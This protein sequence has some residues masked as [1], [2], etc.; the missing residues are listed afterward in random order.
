[1]R[2]QGVPFYNAKKPVDVNKN[3]Q[4]GVSFKG[5][6]KNIFNRNT[7]MTLLMPLYLGINPTQQLN[8]TNQD[9]FVSVQI[10]ENDTKKKDF[11]YFHNKKY[12]FTDSVIRAN[13]KIEHFKQ[14]NTP[15]CPILTATKAISL[16]PEGKKLIQSIIQPLP[17]G[18]FNVELCTDF[19]ENNYVVTRKDFFAPENKALSTLDDDAKIIEIA[20]KKYCEVNNQKFSFAPMDALRLL[21]CASPDITVSTENSNKAFIETV[22]D[23]II[24]DK[25]TSAVQELL[26]YIFDLDKEKTKNSVFILSTKDTNVKHGLY[27]NHAYYVTNMQLKR[28]EEELLDG[29]FELHN[30]HNTA[31]K[32]IKLNLYQLLETMNNFDFLELTPSGLSF[33]GNKNISTEALSEALAKSLKKNI[34]HLALRR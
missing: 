4:N 19:D 20:F 27:E 18:S 15:D 22:G 2:I 1:M 9:E 28:T 26:E 33:K 29:V 10:G 24:V 16:T 34:K 7:A 32:A 6:F 17:D 13:G 11:S 30:P 21:T 31:E 12:E 3:S 5:V 14:G 8:R 25:N 23:Q